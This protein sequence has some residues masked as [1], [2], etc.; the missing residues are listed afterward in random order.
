VMDSSDGS[1]NNLYDGNDTNINSIKFGD[2]ILA[3]DD[4]YVTYRRSLDPSLTWYDRF[5]TNGVRQ[6]VAVP[7]TLSPLTRSAS[8]PPAHKEVGAASGPRYIAVAAD[9]VQS[10]GLLNVEIPIRVLAADTLP[11]RVMMLGVE[12]DPLD[13]SPPITNAV[14][15]TAVSG[16]DT[17]D[18]ISASFGVNSYGGAWLDSTV[19][20]VSGT[21]LIG[22]LNVTLPTN[23][24]ANSAYL[25][26]FDHFSASPNG[27]A[28]FHASVKDGLITVGNRTGSSWND[29]IP[30]TWRL[31]YFGTVSNPLSAA[32]ADP[33]GDGAS[34]WQEYIAGTNPMDATSVFKLLPTTTAPGG[35]FALQWTSVVNK[36]YSLQSSTSLSSG[37][38]TTVA[39]NLTGAGQ[40]LHWTDPDASATAKF[41]RAVVQ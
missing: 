18:G 5:W 21:T 2:G 24:T 25:V 22:T 20:G 33:D 35:G 30:D 34:N 31:L 27:L 28:L 6:A 9:Q 8:P 41:Y 38:W 40:A 3:V 37:I 36:T 14:S 32:D 13:G 23:V 17:S 15:F 12:I 7:N 26:H 10:G 19:P 1:D 11:I 16:L 39:T 29:G 4:V